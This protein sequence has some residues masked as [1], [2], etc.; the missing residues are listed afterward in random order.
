[1]SGPTH[2]DAQLLVQLAQLGTSYGMM[3]ALPT[4]FADDF[5]VE[6]ADVMDPPVRTMLS[7][8]ELIGTLVKNDLLNSELVHDWL[9][10][11]GVWARVGP[12]AIRQREKMG[13]PKLFENF[14]AL[15]AAESS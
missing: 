1:M 6:S 14:E 5:D 9:W 8:G 3:E 13:E 12:A 15:A 2:E 4:L 10:I 11:G 7:Y